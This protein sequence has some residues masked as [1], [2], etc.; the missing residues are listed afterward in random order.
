MPD[1]ITLA[2]LSTVALTE[3][4]KFLYG[5]AGEL[6]QRRREREEAQTDATDPIA[7]PL[8]EPPAD[9]L[10]G[11]P[12]PLLADPVVLDTLAGELAQLRTML[13]PYVMGE[14]SASVSDE[15][16]L[17]RVDA[18]RRG[19][20]AVYGQRLTFAGE[21]RTPSGTRVEGSVEAQHVRGVVAG[22][23]VGDLSGLG[24]VK[25]TARVGDIAETGRVSGVEVGPDGR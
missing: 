16:L 1:P 4:I 11:E 10:A 19:L 22:V 7:E 12:M 17:V 2:V 20:E 8:P 15:E 21:A 25:G 18:L 3:G 23:T 9:L 14:R 6:L 5:Q 13:E 24:E